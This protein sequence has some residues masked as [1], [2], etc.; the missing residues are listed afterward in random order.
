MRPDDATGLVALNKSYL[1]LA[2]LIFSLL[3]LLLHTEASLFQ[4]L[5]LL[6]Q[7][8]LEIST[9]LL[10]TDNLQLDRQEAFGFA[11]CHRR[12]KE[13]P[14]LLARR[15]T[16]EARHDGLQALLPSSE[17]STLHT[18]CADARLKSRAALPGKVHTI[19]TRVRASAQVL[20][21]SV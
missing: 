7:P 3:Y 21:R 2:S 13:I 15:L 16:V 19:S 18:V 6:M 11:L 12:Q 5:L 10:C 8:Q 20:C 9:L 14:V 17:V 1:S 4:L